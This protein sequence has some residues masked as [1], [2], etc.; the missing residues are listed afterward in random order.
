MLNDEV[1]SI[2]DWIGFR[3]DIASLEAFFG[4]NA[5]TILATWEALNSTIVLLR[6]SAALDVIISV[7]LS[8][9]DKAPLIIGRRHR[10]LSKYL[11]IVPHR[12]A[13]LINAYIFDQHELDDALQAVASRH[14]PLELVKQL[15]AAG[16]SLKHERCRWSVDGLIRGFAKRGCDEVDLDYLKTLLEA[17]AT[18]DQVPCDRRRYVT[19]WLGPG[20]PVL[21][22]DY[23]LLRKGYSK[24]NNGLWS[25]ISLWSDRQQTTVTVPGI[26][27]AVQGGHEQ[28][29]SYL[30]ARSQPF[31]DQV[32]QLVLEI[33][34]SEAS[35]RGY[36]HVLQSLV[37]FGVDPNV[38]M[39]S[40]SRQGRQ[41]WHPAIR[42][43]NAGQVNMLRSVLN[44]P[45][46][47]IALLD[48]QLGDRR[49][50]RLDLCALRNMESSQLNQ[51]LRL[52]STLDL[53]TATRSG[54]LWKAIERRSCC[55]YHHDPDFGFLNQLLE[56]GLASLNNREYRDGSSHFLVEVIREHCGVRT[57]IY[58]VEL[59]VRVVSALSASTIE[60]L[61]TATLR[62]CRDR[63]EILEFLART[64]E[65]F[66]LYVQDNSSLL[67][68]KSLEYPVCFKNA[69][70]HGDND[71]EAMV[72]VKWLLG[73]G[74]SCNVSD[75]SLLLRHAS[76]SFILAIIDS[77]LSIKETEKSSALTEAIDLGRLNLAVTLIE[78][79]GIRINDS[80]GRGSRTLL[81]QACD[82]C[83][84]LWFIRFL[85]DKGA[86]V[87]APPESLVNQDPDTFVV[88]APNAGSTALQIA[89]STG[90]HSSYVR[91][92]LDEGADVN[93][94]PAPHYGQTAL[95][96]AVRFGSMNTVGLLLDYGADVN[97]LSGC[98]SGNRTLNFL[99]AIDV[100]VQ[101]SKLDMVQFLIVA[102]ARSV[103]PGLTG[104]DG[105]IRIATRCRSYAIAAL[106]QRHAK[107]CREDRMEAE[108]RWLQA[109][110]HARMY[111]GRI[112]L[113]ADEP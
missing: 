105:A 77:S 14:G 75:L 38:R 61:L 19:N 24:L 26:F 73:L 109:N 16:G 78:R 97:A 40:N 13:T 70:E 9:R 101:S 59:D 29:R 91:F 113:R 107:C 98:Y 8:L 85:V 6:H 21:V 43:T 74:A 28:L 83:C 3:A 35:G 58:L 46:I 110:P 1:L 94:R 36:A 71:C 86:D 33:A 66:E 23:L 111:E 27:E 44:L 17:G 4:Q 18:I 51:V 88:P 48:E 99:R 60:A 5:L 67:L 84:P 82:K 81:Q 93:A 102:G 112:E 31:D 32:R 79:W 37:Q 7:H 20:R 64:V 65:G 30:N 55:E 62:R 69:A 95:Q 87:N 63:N 47:D 39:L 96:W 41:N 49:L 50:E 89:C 90:V 42:A 11:R 2:L 108:R 104:F 76:E 68:S 100:A 45:S 106:L 22:T 57:L 80:Q 34:L 10:E 103:H 15:I 25:L 12:A 56:I 54:I 92:L 53:T 72:T 52:L